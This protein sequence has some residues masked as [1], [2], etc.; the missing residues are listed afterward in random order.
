M[1]RTKRG[2][3]LCKAYE[4]WKGRIA[5]WMALFMWTD[6]CSDVAATLIGR[7]RKEGCWERVDEADER[8][9][10]ESTVG[11]GIR[12]VSFSFPNYSL[13]R[14][15]PNEKKKLSTFFFFLTREKIDDVG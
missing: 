7:E 10:V 3:V 13:S 11:R 15:Y 5:K 1:Q 6:F 14:N 4:E 9:I 8:V 12:C 2:K